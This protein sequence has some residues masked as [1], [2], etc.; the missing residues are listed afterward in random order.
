[1]DEKLLRFFKL[2]NY[3]DA[4]AFENATLKD[5]VVNTKENSWTLRLTSENII[6]INSMMNLRKLCAD[7]VE[8]VSKINIEISYDNLNTDD[9]LEYFIYFLN[10][11]I[12]QNP[13]LLG[14]NTDKIRID[15][16][17]IIVE[18]TSKIEETTL[19]KECKKISKMLED[20]GIHGFEISFVINENEVEA[21]KK[22]IDKE[23]SE[24]V[25]PTKME[26]TDKPKWQNRKKVEYQREGIV[27]ISSIA[28]EENSV[29]LE[30]YV[31]DSEF[32]VLTKKDGTP[33]YLVT[34]KISD[35]SSSI[36]A[37]TF[38]RDEEEFKRLGKDLKKGKWFHFV[39]Q[40]RYDDYA[41]D[42]VFQMRDYE[43]IGNPEI[44]RLDEE[45]EKRV[46]LH[47]H[48]M[49]SQMDGVCD[50]IKLV[51]QAIAWGHAGIG[52]T[53]HDCCQS[54]PHVF[55]T[56]TKYN[57]GKKKEFD[58][59]I[60][61][62]EKSIEEL[63]EAGKREGIEELEKYI[64]DL[65]EEK[66]NY[67]PFKVGYGVELEM[68][69]SFLNV[70][71]NANTEKIEGNTF[72]VFDTETTGFNPGLGDS[73]IEVGGVKIHNGEVVDRFDELIN[74]GHH[75]DEQITRVTD[76]SDDDVKDADNE[77]NVV[78]RFKEWIG[79]LPLV[80]HN[81]RFDKNMLDM[82]A[83]EY[84]S[85]VIW[86]NL[87]N[88]FRNDIDVEKEQARIK[89][90]IEK[91]NK[92]GG[93]KAKTIEEYAKSIKDSRDAFLEAYIKYIQTGE[94]IPFIEKLDVPF[95]MIELSIKKFKEMLNNGAFFAVIAD[96]KG[97]L[98]SCS[99]RAIN[100]LV[101]SRINGDISM[102]VVTDPDNWVTY[103]AQNGQIAEY[104][105]DYGVIELDGSLNEQIKR[106]KK[107]Y[108]N[109][110]D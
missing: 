44:K 55:D 5:M 41:S 51:N 93:S 100:N 3:N 56:V 46:E 53:D 78:K 58:A 109:K 69:E 21:I 17:V 76:I 49:M 98:P 7:G 67:K 14:V 70:C 71:F 45:P 102:N 1:M 73:M 72:V 43:E 40:V 54:F 95:M 63:K 105:H 88:K 42:L 85:F 28:R 90:F 83:N 81:A 65:K 74:P 103:Y 13:S 30:A 8:K 87:L 32:N 2:V 20:L 77:E 35:N 48:T 59:K 66:K 33:L 34:L 107:S 29:N 39:G 18:V 52:I 6:N 80:A 96:S 24:V 82:L 75:I 79:N 89:K 62:N 27:A 50:E 12:A 110:E 19:K 38:A 23:K 37:K 15:E 22:Q 9:V 4:L 104:V 16:E 61:E 31:F 64:E 92:F 11:V 108:V 60:A 84:L 57:K 99:C 94:I 86:D 26:N 47:T 97:K 91:M 101:C 25:I 36:L 106:L 68:C 10:K